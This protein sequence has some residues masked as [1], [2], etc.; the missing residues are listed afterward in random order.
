MTPEQERILIIQKFL[1]RKKEKNISFQKI[2]DKMNAIYGG[3]LKRSDVVSMLKPDK[4]IL[5]DN[6]LK[7][8]NVLG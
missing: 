1:E 6:Y 3:N 7:L 8:K 5:M 2:A 4:S